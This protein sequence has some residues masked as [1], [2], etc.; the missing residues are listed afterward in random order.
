[1]SN[2]EAVQYFYDVELRIFE[3]WILPADVEPDNSVNV[4]FILAE[5]G[6]VSSAEVVQSSDPALNES[7]LAAIHRAEPFPEMSAEASCLSRLPIVGT[8]RN[9]KANR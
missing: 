5:S 8:F 9:P 4:R 7:V 6:H 2:P 1:M 3:Q